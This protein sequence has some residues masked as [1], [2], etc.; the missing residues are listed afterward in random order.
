MSICKTLLSG[1]IGAIWAD[2]SV[3]AAQDQ[4]EFC[5][6]VS[7]V[8][9][10]CCPTEGWCIGRAH[11]V[12]VFLDT[13]GLPHLAVTNSIPERLSVLNGRFA[14]DLPNAVAKPISTEDVRLLSQHGAHL[15]VEAQGTPLALVGTQGLE[16]AIDLIKKQAGANAFTDNT[17]TQFG[18]TAPVLQRF[19]EVQ[20]FYNAPPALF[21][22]AIKPQAQMAIRAQNGLA[23]PVVSGAGQHISPSHDTQ[24]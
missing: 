23:L 9:E 10:V 3:H 15:V 17:K 18:K 5:A 6:S 16:N 20:N 13:N 8:W 21:L 14:R 24:E 19:Q 2:H 12:I 11:N 22:P 7:P 1:L 4:L